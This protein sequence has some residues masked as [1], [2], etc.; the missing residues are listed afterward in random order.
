M[1]S[2]CLCQICTCGRHHCPHGSTKIYENSGVPYLTTEY[3]EKY[4]VYGNVLPPQTLKPKQEFPAC[5]G[6]MEGITTFK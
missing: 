6:K 5:G 1:R 4:P 3:L 2:R